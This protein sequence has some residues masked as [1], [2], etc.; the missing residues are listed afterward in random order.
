MVSPADLHLFLRSNDVCR[1]EEEGIVGLVVEGG[2]GGEDEFLKGGVV[3]ADVL[4]R[5]GHGG[6]AVGSCGRDRL[7]R[8]RRTS[9]SLQLPHLIHLPAA[10]EFELNSPDEETFEM[11]ETDAES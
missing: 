4:R 2:G 1:F 7:C 10:A 8:R 11:I 5:A 9:A 3:P 6:A